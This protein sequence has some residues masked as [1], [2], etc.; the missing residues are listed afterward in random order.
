LLTVRIGS[1]LRW[2][3]ALDRQEHFYAGDLCVHPPGVPRNI[4]NVSDKAARVLVTV[5]PPGHERYF[6][7]L[8]KLTA[9]GAPD[10]KA[11]SEL[12]ARFD[13]DQLSAL[14]PRA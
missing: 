8:A 11:I 9:K 10:V 3:L 4:T 2:L 6:E 7:A 14:T 13:T 5:S 1:F 12:R